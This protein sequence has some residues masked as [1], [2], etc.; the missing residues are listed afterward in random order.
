MFKQTLDID[1][2]N[3]LAWYYAQK[4]GIDIQGPN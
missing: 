3:G 2:M 1:T 4:Y